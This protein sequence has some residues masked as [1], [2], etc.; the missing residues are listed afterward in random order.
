MNLQNLPFGSGPVCFSPSRSELKCHQEVKHVCHPRKFLRTSSKPALLSTVTIL[1]PIMTNFSFCCSRTWPATILSISRPLLLCSPLPGLGKVS[2]GFHLSRECVL[3][4]S[5]SHHNKNLEWWT[6][7]PPQR[8]TA[9]G[10]WT[11]CVIA[12]RSWKD[13]VIALRQISVIAQCYSSILFR[14]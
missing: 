12:L 10:S 7:K 8:I 4:G 14:R 6:L 9:L 13:H 3:L 11:D 1:S 2:W 5:L